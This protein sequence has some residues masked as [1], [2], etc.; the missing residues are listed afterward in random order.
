M[1]KNSI[2]KDLRT[3]K[4]RKRIEKKKKGMGSYT[5]KKKNIQKDDST[6]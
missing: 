5:R 2:A 6:N 3:P 4:Y 1:V